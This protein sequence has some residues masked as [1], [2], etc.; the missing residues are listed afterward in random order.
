MKKNYIVVDLG[1]G[2]SRIALVSSDGDILDIRSF[3]NAYYR[4][5]TYEDAQYFLPEEW[6]KII[7]DKCQEIISAN[8]GVEVVAVTSSGA[9][10]TIVL[11][12]KAGHAFF[13]LPN[14][15]NRGRAWMDEI[16]EKEYIYERTG[17]WVTED[18]PAAKL[19]G[20]RKK[21]EDEYNKIAGITSLSEWI[22]WI[23]TGKLVIEPSQACETQLF[24]IEKKEWSDQ[25]CQY[26]KID[27]AI[28]PEIKM[29]GESIG[30]IT[31]EIAE[32]TGIA[33]QVE[34]I[35]GGADTQVAVKGSGIATDDVGIVAGTT[36]PVVTIVDHK[37]YDKEERC[38]TDCNIGGA[39]YQVETNPGVTG[40]NYQR[41]KKAFF[42]EV[43]YAELDQIMAKKKEF[44]CTASFSSLNFA[45]KKSLKKGGFVMGAPFN[46]QMDPTD[47]LWA[48]VADMACAI[49]V[50]YNSL[51]EMIPH[52]K[53]YILGCGGGFQSDVLCQMIS[54][55][56]GKELIIR[57]GFEQASVL[58]C[59]AICNDYY[60][61]S[62]KAAEE[63]EKHFKPEE[64]ALVKAYYPVWFA[65]REMLNAE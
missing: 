17:R 45:K 43:P 52:K 3:E 54:T 39:T 11:I 13:G 37:Y 22:G 29:A 21:Y 12:D 64:D 42:K 53:D 65:N 41:F 58:G 62:S 32:K 46:P 7:L 4:D 49:F 27:K 50:Q 15:D 9:R 57:K 30:T 40:L 48:L 56:T 44:V 51:C 55:L 26:Y 24:D 34:F 5:D 63:V 6:E 25:I 47:L 20:Y 1:T 59:V 19:Y 36:S 60:Q 23:F 33:K 61:I 28:L 16:P 8:P 2:N 10:E 38:W 31:E 18:F 14:I 35:I